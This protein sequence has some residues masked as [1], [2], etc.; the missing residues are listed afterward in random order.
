VQLAA[1]ASGSVLAN[2]RL[3]LY[4]DD[5]APARALRLAQAGAGISAWSAT[6][7]CGW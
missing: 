1:A 6:A 5:L 3:E 2:A 7:G 4:P